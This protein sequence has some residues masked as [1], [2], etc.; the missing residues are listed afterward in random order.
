M[1]T[2]IIQTDAERAKGL[3]RYFDDRGDQAF[4]VSSASE[5]FQLLDRANPDL[6]VLDL[7]CPEAFVNKSIEVITRKYPRTQVLITAQHF[8]V[9]RE[10]SVK[11]SGAGVFLRAPFTE[12]RLERAIAQLANISSQTRL[13][14]KKLQAALPKIRVPVQ[15]KII[16]P[17]LVLAIILAAGAGYLITQVALDAIEDR[18]TNNLI[19]AGRLATAW[20]VEDENRN[21][22]FLRLISHIDGL[23]AAIQNENP[24]TIRELIYGVALNNGPEAIE[25]VNPQGVAAFSMRHIVGGQREDYEFSTQDTIFV[26]QEF[27]HRILRG[28]LDSMG[29]KFAGLISMPNGDFLYFAGPLYSS[30]NQLIGTVHIGQRLNSLVY[31]MRESLLGDNTT[32]AHITF[33]D[34]TGGAKASTLIGENDISLP[35]E[36]VGSILTNQ[37]S[38]S[39]MR[40]ITAAEIGYREILGVWEVRDGIDL[41]ILGVSLAESFLVQPSLTTQI[42]IMIFASMAVLL[43]I[44]IGIYVARLITNPLAS[45]VS[46]AA[47]ISQGKWDVRVEPKGSDELGYLAHAFNSM[48]SH[49]REGEIYRDLLGR[50]ITPQVRDQLRRGISTGNLKLGGQDTVATIII[51]DIRGFT[52]I[53][54][55]ADPTT[56]LSWLDNYYGEL[57]PIINSNNGFI[58]EFAGDSLKAVFGVLPVNLSPQKSAYQACIAALDM[59]DAIE[60]MNDRRTENGEPPLITGIGINTGMVA[61]GVMGS[62]ERLHYAIIGDTVNVPHRHESLTTILGFTRDFISQDTPT[63]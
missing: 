11:K 44:V 3:A 12:A 45:V 39:H 33:Y 7:H 14:S 52:K 6:V 61:A 2:L 50:T 17:Y 21:L 10:L 32:F 15:F 35:N 56:I 27:V 23:S 42:Q 47:N 16:L 58:H 19:E 41:G 49:L 31:D 38:E 5:F 20:M 8:D 36:M 37:L 24:D 40:T 34:P 43:I 59:L 51:T 46:A 13:A 26:D 30:E 25:I 57:A 9:D 60:A 53:S 48:T 55:T 28:E 29:D 63:A 54:D 62:M 1:L 18:F 4:I 22:E